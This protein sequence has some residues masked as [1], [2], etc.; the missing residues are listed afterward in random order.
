MFW[1]KR[2]AIFKEHTQRPCWVKNMLRCPRLR[3]HLCKKLGQL[4]SVY[5]SWQGRCKI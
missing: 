2:V 1:L 3:Y 5:Y 4:L